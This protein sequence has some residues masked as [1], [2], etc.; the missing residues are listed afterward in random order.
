[1]DL[2]TERSKGFGGAKLSIHQ[3][4]TPFWAFTRFRIISGRPVCAKRTNAS[5]LRD[6]ISAM[7]DSSLKYASIVS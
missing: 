6:S 7:A 4:S 2:R 1:M 3:G 5:A